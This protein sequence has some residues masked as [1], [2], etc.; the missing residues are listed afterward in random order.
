MVTEAL[1]VLLHLLAAFC[2]VM[3][4]ALEVVVVLVAVQVDPVVVEVT[5]DH[6]TVFE[7][8]AVLVLQAKVITEEVGLIM[9]WPA[10]LAEVEV[11]LL[12]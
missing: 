1:A 2:L 7:V 8:M 9:E 3:A 5:V 11:D 10:L 12:V 4:V 6:R